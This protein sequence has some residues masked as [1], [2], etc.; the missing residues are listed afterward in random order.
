MKER[1]ELYELR[2]SILDKGLVLGFIIGFVSYLITLF[3]GAQYGFDPGFFAIT[4]GVLY[5]A[6]IAWF[7]KKIKPNMKIYS[8]MFVVM[9]AFVSGLSK[10]GFLIS[11]KSFIILIAVFV[12]FVFN[13][14]KALWSLFLF[15]G[16]YLLFGIL[17]IKGIL[18]F[19]IEV[20]TYSLSATAWIMDV[21]I[22]VLVTLSLLYVAKYFSKT[23]FDKLN[24]INEK[25]IDLLNREKKYRLLFENSIDA[26]VLLKNRKVYDVNNSALKLFKCTKEQAIGSHI[27][28]FFPDRQIDS[29]LASLKIDKIVTSIKEDH[30]LIVESRHIKY[31]GEVFDAAISLSYIKIEGELLYQVVVRDITEQKKIDVELIN[32]RMHLESLIQRRTEELEEIN[33]ALHQSNED[34]REQRNKLELALM[35]VKNMQEKLIE[36]DKMVS[37]GVLTAGVAHEINNPLNFIQTGIYTLQNNLEK[38]HKCLAN[39]EKVKEIRTVYQYMEEG[40]ER[41]SHIVNSLSYF[42]AK[43]GV[44]FSCCDIVKILNNCLTILEYETKSRIEIIRE[45]SQD[46]IKIIGQETDLHQVFIN[47]FYNAIQSI[48]KQGSVKVIVVPTDNKMLK[49]EIIDN[50]K[51]M[52][53]EVR[54]KMFDPFFTTKVQGEGTGLGLSKVFNVVKAHKGQ[55]IVDSEIGKG[56]RFVVLLPLN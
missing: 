48:E 16:V 3:R 36:S 18:F 11:S 21:V 45:Y 17:Y 35:D 10:Y 52:S 7:R 31:N 37:L 15:T 4:F 22:I 29:A 24:V 1:D 5:L 28:R 38:N 32:Y 43:K 26:I 25:N 46:S 40:V 41:I 13:Y 39:P 42:G 44:E 19:D 14:K 2:N 54:S 6:V 56:T 23:I 20:E 8:A 34:L 27:D 53:P 9:L 12:S 51:G 49:V 55:I 50:G 30:S 33:K 47:V